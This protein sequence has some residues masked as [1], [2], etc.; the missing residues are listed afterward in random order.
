MSLQFDRVSKKT[1]GVL[2]VSSL[3]CF[4]LLS[5]FIL[6]HLRPRA[7]YISNMRYFWHPCSALASYHTRNREGND[8]RGPSYSK[9]S[10]TGMYDNDLR[11]T[12]WRNGAGCSS[13]RKY[14]FNL[15][16]WLSKNLG[17]VLIVAIT[18]SFRCISW[19][20]SLCFWLKICRID[21][22]W[23]CPCWG[24]AATPGNEWTRTDDGGILKVVKRI[25]ASSFFTVE[26]RGIA[27]AKRCTERRVYRYKNSK[28][29]IMIHSHDYQ[30]AH[31]PEKHW[32]RFSRAVDW[33]IS[34][35]TCSCTVNCTSEL[36]SRPDS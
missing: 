10:W 19:P 22:L 28:I 35:S 21:M 32:Q 6:C 30:N 26:A 17:R 8:I 16:L 23:V 14:G 18:Q 9:K 20:D 12:P 1:Y 34:C 4:F 2:I 5:H 3:C 31:Q 13:L 7:S 33:L 24:W 25:P 15:P 27:N 36:K 29:Y 11:T